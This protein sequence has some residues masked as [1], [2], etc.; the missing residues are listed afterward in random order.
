MRAVHA[1][2]ASGIHPSDFPRENLLQ[3]QPPNFRTYTF[4]KRAFPPRQAAS[5]SAMTSNPIISRLVVYLSKSAWAR[6]NDWAHRRRHPLLS[7]LGSPK[8]V[9]IY[10]I[11][12]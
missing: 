12:I 9:T 11:Q 3:S 2:K 10:L 8:R 4:F 1:Q 5:P 6:A 7:I